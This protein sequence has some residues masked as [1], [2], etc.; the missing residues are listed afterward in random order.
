[1]SASAVSG[2]RPSSKTLTSRTDCTYC[3]AVSAAAS[4]ESPKLAGQPPRQHQRTTSTSPVSLRAGVRPS[5][6]SKAAK[7]TQASPSPDS[8]SAMGRIERRAI[9]PV[10]E[11]RTRSRLSLSKEVE[12]VSKSVP[13]L[14]PELSTKRRAA[15]QTSG[16]SCHSSTRCG[17]SPTRASAGSI[18]AASR[19][20][21][22]SSLVMLF[23]RVIAV[24]VL[25]H[26]LGPLISTQPN[27][28]IRASSL[29]SMSLGL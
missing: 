29:P 19:S 20:D 6:L 7:E 18:S 14:L 22:S 25:P 21:G 15:S 8:H 4:S 1:M 12:P 13:R 16:T 17:S 28:A 26:H 3:V 11:C 23:A 9:L 27:A 10:P 24:H 2:E 5:P